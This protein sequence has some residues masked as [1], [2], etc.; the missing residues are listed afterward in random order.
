MI[1]AFVQFSSELVFWL[2]LLFGKDFYEATKAFEILLPTLYLTMSFYFVI[3]LSQANYY[4]ELV[5]LFNGK[6]LLERKFLGKS[7]TLLQ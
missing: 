5:Q 3:V 6:I 1:S 7:I 4:N 2:K